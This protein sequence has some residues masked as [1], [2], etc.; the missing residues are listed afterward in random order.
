MKANGIL[1]LALALAGVLLTGAASAQEPTLS[2]LVRVGDTIP[3]YGV[4]NRIDDITVNDHGGWLAEVRYTDSDAQFQFLI[5]KSGEVMVSTGDPVDPPPSIVSGT[6][7]L[8]K[9]LNN[10]GST[11][12]RLALSGGPAANGMYYDLAPFVL[13]NQVSTAPQL[14]PG[15]PYIGF[16]RARLDDSERL[17]LVATV[18]DAALPGSVHRALVWFEPDGEGGWT[19]DAM[20]V[21]YDVLP[22]MAG[23]EFADEFG[24]T[25]YSFKIDNDRNA[26]YTVRIGG[27]PGATNGAIYYNDTMLVRKGDLSPIPGSTYLDID[28]GTRADMNNLGDYVFRANLSNL[29][30]EEN[31]AILFN[32][33]FDADDDVVF[34]RQGDPAPGTGEVIT[35][36]GTGP[37]ARINDSGDVVWFA[38]LSGDTNTNQALF[39]GD[40]ILMRKG[41]TVVEGSVVTTVGG[42]TAT[43]GITRGFTS[44][45]NGR[46]ILTRCVLDG[47]TQAAVLIELDPTF[48]F[49]D[50]FESGDAGAW[51]QCQGCT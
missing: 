14:T 28:S 7:N 17:F 36:F 38:T 49:A 1:R 33:V 8:F 19:E 37:S 2:V 40:E 27:A 16:F 41:V 20:A 50:G 42:T 24:T 46:Y 23:G 39:A 29:P 26:L 35:G 5:L 43:G 44:S 18:N 47:T 25:Y 10:H 13:V 6:S 51:S 9:A 21:R 11:A 22:G 30:V 45:Q 32:N 12:F 31:T 15:T 34:I 48:I 3:G 4:V